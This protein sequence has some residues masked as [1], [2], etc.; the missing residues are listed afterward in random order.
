MSREKVDVEQ[1]KKENE[2]LKGHLSAA[3]IL[4]AQ[5]QQ[6]LKTTEAALSRTVNSVNFSY[7][8][9]ILKDE[10]TKSLERQQLQCIETLA[11]M[12]PKGRVDYLYSFLIDLIKTKASA[13]QKIAY[14]DLYKQ[15]SDMLRDEPPEAPKTPPPEDEQPEVAPLKS[16]FATMKRIIAA[17]PPETARSKDMVNKALVR[18]MGPKWCTVPTNTTGWRIALDKTSQKN[19]WWH[20]TT[21]ATQWTTPEAVQNLVKEPP[22]KRAKIPQKR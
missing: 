3:R 4:M 18:L 11:G 9:P 2:L 20:A 15:A 16:T 8:P 10:F 5:M 19:Y 7:N 13:F 22:K 1:L 17:P 12:D 14:Y 6:K 21:K